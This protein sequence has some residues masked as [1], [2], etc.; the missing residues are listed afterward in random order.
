M[1]EYFPDDI[2]FD[3]LDIMFKLKL[4]INYLQMRCN[5]AVDRQ[6]DIAIDCSG[7]A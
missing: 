4:R 2:V 7:N 3:I 1:L 5:T 6:I